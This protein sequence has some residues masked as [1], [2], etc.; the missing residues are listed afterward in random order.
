M[1]LNLFS[2]VLLGRLD[3]QLFAHHC[4]NLYFVLRCIFN[5]GFFVY[6]TVKNKDYDF[7][8]NALTSRIL[9]FF[10]N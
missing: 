4:L 7:E 2:D 3:L 5:D 10:V 8:K 1:L 9:F 6:V